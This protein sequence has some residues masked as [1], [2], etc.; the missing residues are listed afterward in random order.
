[1]A[2]EDN[3]NTSEGDGGRLEVVE[4]G[5][6]PPREIQELIDLFPTPCTIIEFMMVL[7]NKP[8]TLKIQSLIFQLIFQHIMDPRFQ[9]CECKDEVVGS[10]NLFL[11]SLK[12]EKDPNAAMSAKIE[13]ISMFHITEEE[14]KY[15][16]NPRVSYPKRREIFL[17]CLMHLVNGDC[18]GC[19]EKIKAKFLEMRK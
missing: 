17:I 18:P 11:K 16:F 5:N 1:M 7:F 19:K 13:R 9:S 15:I 3:G 2:N 10:L 12:W 14:L 8:I 6:K 4:A